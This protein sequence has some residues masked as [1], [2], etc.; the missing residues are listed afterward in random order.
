MLPVQTS[1]SSYPKTRP[2]PHDELRTWGLV[3]LFGH[4]GEHLLNRSGRPAVAYVS[5]ITEFHPYRRMRRHTGSRLASP[6]PNS[7]APSVLCNQILTSNHRK[8]VS[9]AAPSACAQHSAASSWIRPWLTWL[10][11]WCLL[12]LNLKPWK[13]VVLL[14]TVSSV[15]HLRQ[16]RCL[17]LR[18]CIRAATVHL[19]SKP[20]NP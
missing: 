4:L 14:F 17:A 1:K 9:V 19:L 15:T 20:L 6:R 11:G 13:D 10:R 2:S 7:Q 5:I 16:L 18:R 3:Y 12:N 8:L